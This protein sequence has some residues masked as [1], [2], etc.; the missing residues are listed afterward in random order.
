MSALSIAAE[1]PG[2]YIQWGVIQISVANA[3]I[4]GVMILLFI[5]ALVVP[6]P[7]HDEQSDEERHGR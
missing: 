2:K 3:I 7:A 6:F 1:G 5:L 4:I